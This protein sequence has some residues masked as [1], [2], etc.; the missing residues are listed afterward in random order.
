[1]IWLLGILAVALSTALTY[2]VSKGHYLRWLWFFAVLPLVAILLLVGVFVVNDVRYLGLH[3]LHYAM[4]RKGVSTERVEQLMGPPIIR[5]D[6]V[7]ALTGRVTRESDFPQGRFRMWMSA[8]QARSD[9]ARYAWLDKVGE[10][11]TWAERTSAHS[12]E[13]FVTVAFDREGRVLRKEGSFCAF[14]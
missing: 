1:M 6:A 13:W 7:P 4:I 2:V 10:V 12:T 8:E 3:R 14:D 11:W 5:N 9:P